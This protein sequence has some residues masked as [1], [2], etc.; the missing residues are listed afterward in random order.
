MSEWKIYLLEDAVEKLI[1]YRGKTPFKTDSGIPLIT[2]KVIKNGRIESPNEFIAEDEYE[3]WMTRGIPEL[4]DVVLT[5]E[6]PLGEV[7]QIKTKDKVAL[8]QRVITLRGKRN[9]VDSTYLKYFLF[10]PIGQGNL[11]AKETGSTVTGIKQSE[12]RKVEIYAPDYNAQIGIASIL[13]SLDDKIELNLQMNQTLERMAQAIFKEWFVNFNFPGFD[14]ELVDG[15]P[16]GWRMGKVADTC[17]V[18]SNTLSAKDDMELIQYIEIS[19]VEKGIVKNI[20]NYKRGEEPSRAKRKLFH[21][22]VVLSTVRPNRGSYFL[23]IH[24]DVNLVASTGFAVFTPTLVPFSYLYCFLT[25]EEQIEYYGRMADGGAYP[26]I[27]PNVIMK[28][29]FVIPSNNV[30]EMFNDVAENLYLRIYENHSENKTLTQI[31]DSLLPKLMTGKIEVK[32]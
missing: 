32:E 7:A 30:L 22:D 14:G 8:A 13:S 10:S 6:A 1:D 3:S 29:D 27:N 15:L 16:K 23:A 4:G 24:P 5:T 17:K 19:E 2:A 11:K 21:G 26:A 31:R 20:A 12:L 28:I 9:V 25:N 18:N